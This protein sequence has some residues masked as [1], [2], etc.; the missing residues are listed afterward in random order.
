MTQVPQFDE[1]FRAVRREFRKAGLI[2]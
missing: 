2:D 1:V